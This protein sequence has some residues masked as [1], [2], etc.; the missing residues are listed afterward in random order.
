MCCA[1][2]L[3]AQPCV[4]ECRKTFVD[5]VTMA[6]TEGF[7]VCQ[8]RCEGVW[9]DSC[10]KESELK[11]ESVGKKDRKERSGRNSTSVG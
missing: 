4:E 5:R 1:L 10:T 7:T 11:T 3:A 6:E 9:K 2:R 8:E